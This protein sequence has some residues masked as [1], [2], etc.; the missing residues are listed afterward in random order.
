MTQVTIFEKVIKYIPVADETFAGTPIERRRGLKMTP[1]P[2][3]RAPAT[4]PPVKPR[5]RT[6]L[7]VLPLKIKSLSAILMPPNFS[8]SP[9][10]YA[11]NLVEINTCVIMQIMKM[12]SEV[13][14]PPSHLSKTLPLRI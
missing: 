10:S 1:P 5:P 13:Q 9:Y 2:R 8:L 7:R 3:P 4:H 6:F 11:T 14:S 12:T